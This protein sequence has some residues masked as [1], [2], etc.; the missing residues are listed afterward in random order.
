MWLAFCQL[1]TV[2]VGIFF[3]VL[4]AIVN[5]WLVRNPNFCVI[6]CESIDRAIGKNGLVESYS[7]IR[8]KGIFSVT[9]FVRGIRYDLS[10][11]LFSV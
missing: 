2:V 3:S 4:M 6:N 8:M 7:T 11:Q 1:C 10:V 9:S 5:D